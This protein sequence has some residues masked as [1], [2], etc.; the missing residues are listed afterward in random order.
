ML[1][2]PC[3]TPS[4]R[5]Q[6]RERSR[7]YWS[8][9][10]VAGGLKLYLVTRTW[11]GPSSLLRFFRARRSSITARL[12]IG[13]LRFFSYGTLPT[14]LVLAKSRKHEAV[15]RPPR[16]SNSLGASSRRVT[17]PL[18]GFGVVSSCLCSTGRLLATDQVRVVR[19]TC[20][21][22][23]SDQPVRSI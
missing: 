17:V 22:I 7:H 12:S 11:N 8:S 14:D 19:N 18:P 15:Q 13:E 16:Y 21:C 4:R 5:L 2:P 20:L 10:L 9:L 3:R 6:S 1:R 23:P